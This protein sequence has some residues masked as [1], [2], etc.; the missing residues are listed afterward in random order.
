M[1]NRL[2]VTPQLGD[3]LPRSTKVH[4]SV[5]APP[6][7]DHA[8]SARQRTP[9]QDPGSPRLVGVSSQRRPARGR[10]RPL[11]AAVFGP[12]SAVCFPVHRQSTAA[13]D[14]HRFLG[15]RAAAD[16]LP[17]DRAVLLSAADHPCPD[18]RPLGPGT[19][20]RRLE[21]DRRCQPGHLLVAFQD[22]FRVGRGGF[23]PMDLDCRHPAGQPVLV[24]CRSPARRSTGETPVRFHRRRRHSGFDR[25]RPASELGEQ[26]PRHLYSS[27]TGSG[28]AGGPRFADALLAAPIRCWSATHRDCKTRR[29]GRAS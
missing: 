24:L 9:R 15:R 21:S 20:D 26:P 28:G 12:F 16:R 3:R 8:Q 23:L 13:I 2:L 7:D 10:S 11:L 6:I 14:L 1:R 5:S 27:A 25:R 29:L 18:G 22:S 17:I 4:R 19:P